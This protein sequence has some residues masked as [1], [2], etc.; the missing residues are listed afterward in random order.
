MMY[1]RICVRDNT[2]S[3]TGSSLSISLMYTTTCMC[4][5]VSV[6][7]PFLRVIE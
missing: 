4:V 3:Y 7:S 2:D 5:I 1:E 6:F